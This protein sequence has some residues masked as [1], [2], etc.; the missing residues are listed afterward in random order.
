MQKSSFGLKH[1]RKRKMIKWP[2][3]SLNAIQ[4][5]FPTNLQWNSNIH[6]HLV[7]VLI[8]SNS[9]HGFINAKIISSINLP[10]QLHNGLQVM[11]SSAERIKSTGQR[12][13]VPNCLGNHLFPV[14][15]FVLYLSGFDMVLVN[16]LK[17]LGPI[18]WIFLPCLYL[19]LTMEDMQNCKAR[20]LLS[21]LH[22]TL[23]PQKN[24]MTRRYNCFF[25]VLLQSSKRPQDAH[26]L[27]DR[28]TR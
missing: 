25:V 27:G 18:S 15:L 19:L 21:Q 3:R 10:V 4:R 5:Q 12:K 28:I 13:D 6:G 14:N 8:D 22:S 17:T 20:R 16:W 26:P 1:L 23:L 24:I 11:M 7:W 9:T 2:T